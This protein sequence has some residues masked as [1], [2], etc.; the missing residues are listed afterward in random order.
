MSSFQVIQSR[1]DNDFEA[2]QEDDVQNKEFLNDMIHKV[3]SNENT[4]KLL[5]RDQASIS[6]PNNRIKEE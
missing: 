4:I 5:M 1:N 6:L 3:K 2:E